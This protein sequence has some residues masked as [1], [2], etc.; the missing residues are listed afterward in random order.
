[1]SALLLDTHAFI[2]LS[3]GNSALPEILRGQIDASDKVF[4]SI[5]SFWEMA[6]K[7]SIGK[8]T[9]QKEFKE[10][11]EEFQLTRLLLL[12]IDIKDTAKVQ[13]LIFHHKDPFDRIIIAQALNRNLSL[14]SCDAVFDAYSV[15]RLWSAG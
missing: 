10:I 6:I 4:V 5:A 7:V 12:P 13:T 2:W 8:L 3:E 15:N 9:L 1:M 14:V 11:E